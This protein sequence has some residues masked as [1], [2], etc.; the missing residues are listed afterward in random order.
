MHNTMTQGYA[1]MDAHNTG[2][3]IVQTCLINYSHFPFLLKVGDIDAEVAHTHVPTTSEGLSSVPSAS[4]AKKR[5]PAWS[6][7]N[8]KQC[9]DLLA[10]QEHYLLQVFSNTWVNLDCFCR[11]DRSCRQGSAC[12][13]ATWPG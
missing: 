6:P 8:I 10:S 3:V 2:D 1:S 7:G 4:T 13:V 9:H 12:V 11:Q 5:D